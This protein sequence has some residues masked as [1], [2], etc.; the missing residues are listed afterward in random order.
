VSAI[1]AAGNESAK[2][3]VSVA[4]PSGSGTGTFTFAATEDATIES[5]HPTVNLNIRPTI[6]NSPQN[7][8]LLKFGVAGT[9]GC[10]IISAKLRR[11]WGAGRTSVCGGDVYDS[12]G[13]SQTAVT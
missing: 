1:D 7:Y 6:E 4:M 12:S 10:I 9:N 11:W 13:W 8:A 3:N 5:S 2:S